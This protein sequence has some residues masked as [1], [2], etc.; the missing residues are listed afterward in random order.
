MSKGYD[1]KASE[2]YFKPKDRFYEFLE[3]HEILGKLRRK[4]ERKGAAYMTIFFCAMVGLA[5]LTHENAEFVLV[6]KIF[7]P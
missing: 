3:Q 2:K 6:T 1:N 7:G 5:F 4:Q